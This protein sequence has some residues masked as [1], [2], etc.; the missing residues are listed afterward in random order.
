MVCVRVVDDK[1]DGAI[2]PLLNEHV[3][4]LS[5]GTIEHKQML[6]FVI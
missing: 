6:P 1:G 4:Q 3:A 5:V 2:V